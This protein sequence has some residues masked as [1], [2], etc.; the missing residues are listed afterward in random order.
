MTAPR[1]TAKADQVQ[2]AKRQVSSAF[3]A[4]SEAQSTPVTTPTERAVEFVWA[5]MGPAPVR[6]CAHLARP[7]PVFLFGWRPGIFFCEP[8]AAAAVADAEG[9]A[10]DYTCAR[11]GDYDP[12]GVHAHHQQWGPLLVTYGVCS[13]CNRHLADS[14]R[15]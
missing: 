9:T 11:C 2:A 15:R 7:Q 14:P 8:C 1:S 12:A 10:E 3:D 6:R 13:A 5:L 4:L